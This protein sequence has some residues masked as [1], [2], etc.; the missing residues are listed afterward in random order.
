[1]PPTFESFREG[2][3]PLRVRSANDRPVVPSG[4]FVL[5]WMIAA[6]RAASNFALDRAMAWAIEI[7]VP[8]VVFEAIR[9]NYPFASDRLHRFVID[10][11]ADNGRAFQDS[12]VLYFPYVEPAIGAGRGL[13][14]RLAQD[15][16]VVVTDEFPCF[17]LPEAVRAAARRL[18]VR[19]ETVDSNGLLPL[20][21]VPQAYPAAVHLRRFMQGTL[22]NHLASA[23]QTRPRFDRL[24]TRL[25]SL[26]VDVLERWPSVSAELLEGSVSALA[27]LPIDHAVSSVTTQG[28]S[29]AAQRALRTFVSRRLTTYHEHQSHPDDRGTSRLSPYL[30]FGHLSSHEVFDAVMRHER[31]SLGKLGPK[32][33]GAREGWWGVGTGAEAFLDQLVVWRELGF[34]TCARRPDD[35]SRFEGLPSWAQQTLVDHARDRRPYI[36]DR[37]VFERGATHDPLWNA[38][39]AELVRHGWMHNYMRMLWGKKILEWSASPH[40]ALDTMMAIMDRWAVDGRDPN[41]YAGYMWTLGR[42]DRPW[43][44]RPIYGTVRSMSSENTAKKVRVKQYVASDRLDLDDM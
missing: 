35:Y 30:H 5:Y 18:A 14:E 1:M 6:R 23:P 2:A 19:L 15:A 8:L 41:S 4:R 22:R 29:A 24:P 10:G 25:A 12:P 11:M 36:Y 26:P 16:A 21:S 40:E 38:A 13:L 37:A 17:F 39:Q 27:S 9:A 44:E 43:P 28:G 32:P 33:T 20:A 3:P 34:N 31:W 7:G 42:Y